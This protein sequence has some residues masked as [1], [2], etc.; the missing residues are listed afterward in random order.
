[1]AQNTTSLT[2]TG[3]AA[4]DSISAL[5][6]AG[7]VVSLL[8]ALG[9][10]GV[11]GSLVRRQPAWLALAGASLSA[12]AGVF[13]IFRNP[14]RSIPSAS[15]VVI[16]PCDGDV[17]AMTVVQEPRLLKTPA[18]CITLRV[19]P[20]DVQILRAPIAGTVRRR[21]Y[22]TAGQSGEDRDALWIGIRQ[23]AAA[24]LLKLGVSRFWRVMPNYAGRRITL[25]IDLEDATQLG[26]VCGHL[27]LG[28]E[29][30]VY[31][32]ATARVAVQAGARVR[33]GETIL[34]RF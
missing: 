10:S 8:A 7:G 32:P 17:R 19:R 12:L 16:A 20:G 27:P 24:V 34:A 30:Q 18:H 4:E 14:D 1:M 2:Q 23:P 6:Q 31:V 11:A 15:G 13:W 29:V 25:L 28:G 3:A 22:V 26:Q 33:A 5:T 21:R 9:L